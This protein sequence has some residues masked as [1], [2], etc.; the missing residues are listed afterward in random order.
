MTSRSFAGYSVV[1]TLGDGGMM[2]L[3]LALD[4]HGQRVVVRYLQEEFA[5]RWNYRRH[6]LRG[7]QVLAELRHPNI[8]QLLKTGVE[9]RIPYMVL[10]YVEARTLRELILGRDP[11]LV[12]NTLPM[13]RQLIGV[14]AFIHGAGYMHMDLKPENIL[15]RN[16]GMI[17]L[18]D[19][20]LARKRGRRPFRWFELPGT[21]AYTAPETLLQR[22]V[23]ERS[24]I[25]SMG[26]VFY[27]MLT[28]HKPYEGSSLDQVRTDHVNPA[29]QP[30]RPR[31]HDA[32]IPL[33]LER[34]VLKCIAK[35]PE[36]RYPSTSLVIRDLEALR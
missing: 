19:F 34:I 1:R 23:D 27:E 3:L 26:V 18:I 20:D 2:R 13:I 16:D 31:Q 35:Q 14:L 22:K 25:Y 9:G 33:D 7:A 11:L 36:D 29:V 32:S 15:V 17:F 12:K 28:F 8:V 6:F 24:D 10:E 30:T 5:R 21:P 4:D